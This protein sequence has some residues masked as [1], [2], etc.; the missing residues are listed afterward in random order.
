MS[1]HHIIYSEAMRH[2]VAKSH[3]IICSWNGLWYT[4]SETV[5]DIV[6]D[7]TGY[8][9]DVVTKADLHKE[10]REQCLSA[11]SVRSVSDRGEETAG[12]DQHQPQG[13]DIPAAPSPQEVF[14]HITVK[15]VYISWLL[16][17]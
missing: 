9:I 5:R 3:Y 6:Y 13:E 1:F 16:I 14:K 12:M 2:N 10:M 4:D 11:M 8:D 17:K 15:P 7:T